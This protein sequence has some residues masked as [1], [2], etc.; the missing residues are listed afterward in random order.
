MIKYVYIR[1]TAKW[2]AVN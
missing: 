1:L 2:V